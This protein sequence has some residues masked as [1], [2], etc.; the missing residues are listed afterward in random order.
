M[1]RLDRA[2]DRATR[3]IQAQ[4][5]ASDTLVE[6]GPREYG[7]LLPAAGGD[8]VPRIL[9]R[10]GRGGGISTFCYGLAACPGDATESGALVALATARLPSR[11]Q[12]SVHTLDAPKV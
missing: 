5:R 9:A 10:V 1:L 6:L 4:L 7:I 8:E 12:P 3:Q 11:R 2:D